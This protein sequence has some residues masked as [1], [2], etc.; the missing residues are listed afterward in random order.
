VSDAVLK[1]RRAASVLGLTIDREHA[2]N[3]ISG[4]VTAALERAIDGAAEDPKLRAVIITGAGER[5][6]SAGGDIKQYRE[7]RERADLDT[8]FAGP[9][10]LMDR[11]E[12]LPL[13]VIA[14]INGYALGGGA[15]LALAC[16][17]RIAAP[18][19]RI[20]FPYVRLGLMP[21]WHGGE[22]LLRLCGYGNAMHLLMTGATLDAGVA[23]D[24]G[25]VSEVVDEMPV[26]EAA[27]ALA[28]RLAEGAPLSLAAI[29]RSLHAT[30]T[31]ERA[32]ARRLSDEL[33]AGLWLSDDHREAEAAFAGKRTPRFRGA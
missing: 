18:G 27:M 21:G 9:R 33:F 3:A 8:A 29:K 26:M 1:I 16:D 2:G 6:F 28:A 14:A 31:R 12:A 15:E 13:P 24:L 7:L 5:F 22:R 32:V 25:L 19:A 20:G 4:A 23:R 10:R 17:I 30:A 11:I